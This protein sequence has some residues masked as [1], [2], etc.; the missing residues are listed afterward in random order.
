M[1]DPKRAKMMIGGV[2]VSA[3]LVTGPAVIRPADL[4]LPPEL[5]ALTVRQPFAWCIGH[6]Q[7]GLPRKDDEN[8][9]KPTKYRG[10]VLIHAA[11]R[12]SLNA[13]EHNLGAVDMM[14]GP[15]TPKRLYEHA[16]YGGFLAIARITGCEF[17]SHARGPIRRAFIKTTGQVRE[18]SCDGWRI[19]GMYAW[20]LEDIRP[21]PFVPY[22]PGFL[23]FW[24]VDSARLGEHRAAYEAAWTE[25]AGR[26]A[27]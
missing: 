11:E 1:I 12:G 21:L 14:G 27:A 7:H 23:G 22:S 2:D 26:A 16:L 5:R 6:D 24:R 17:V 9:S 25:L 13:Y 4:G 18:V 20:H 10:P 8:R 3:S 19:L 15:G